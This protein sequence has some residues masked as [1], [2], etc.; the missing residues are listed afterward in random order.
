LPFLE[1][2]QSKGGKTDLY[3]MIEDAVMALQQNGYIKPPRKQLSY[4]R[5]VIKDVT[6]T[7]KPLPEKER[8]YEDLARKMIDLFP[9]GTQPNTGY[10]WRCSLAK[11]VQRL[12]MLNN[13]KELGPISCSDE[14]ILRATR[15]YV[16]DMANPNSRRRILHYFIIKQVQE[17]DRQVST[18]ELLDWVELTQDMTE[19]EMQRKAPVALE[20]ADL[21]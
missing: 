16:A 6:L 19:E 13:N 14:D 17:G 8:D 4:G 12:K 15:A 20:E 3:S 10:P 18:S 1:E 2:F 9:R 7:G 5:F 11:C 21:L